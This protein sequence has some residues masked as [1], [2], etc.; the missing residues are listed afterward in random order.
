MNA[1]V[2]AAISRTTPG[3]ARSLGW[4]SSVVVDVVDACLTEHSVDL[5]G[6][7]SYDGIAGPGLYHLCG[8]ASDLQ[9]ARPVHGFIRVHYGLRRNTIR[10]GRKRC[11]NVRSKTD[12]VQLNLQHG[13]KIRKLKYKKTFKIKL[14]VH[15]ANGNSSWS[16]RSRSFKR[17]KKLGWERFVE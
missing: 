16:P 8:V 6:S 9:R 11:F 13:T 3:D 2:E 5:L 15:R 1:T 14:D 7:P 17:N 4:N 10:Y 12:I